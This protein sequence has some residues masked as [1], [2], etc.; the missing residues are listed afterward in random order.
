M[1]LF[2][3]KYGERVRVIKYGDSIELCGGTHVANTGAIGMIRIVSESSIAAGIR[4]IDAVTGEPIAGATFT[5][6]KTDSAT[7]TT[8]T[9]DSSGEIYLKEME[10]GVYE[11]TEQSV[12]DEYLLD[13]VPQQITLEPNKL[14]V[15]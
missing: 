2:G 9:T 13:P 14:D 6:R 3:E 10:P 12:P 5:I 1:A 7:L 15:V 8:E 4:R 11:I